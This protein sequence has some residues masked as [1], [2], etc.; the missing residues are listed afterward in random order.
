MK[1]FKTHLQKRTKQIII[2][3]DKNFQLIYHIPHF[4]ILANLPRITKLNTIAYSSIQSNIFQTIHLSIRTSKLK[5]A[6][7][8]DLPNTPLHHIGKPY[9]ELQN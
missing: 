4:A 3:P 1:T 8:T 9:Q 7:S 5:L 2:G 6:Q